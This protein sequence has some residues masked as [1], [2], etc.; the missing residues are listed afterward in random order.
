MKNSH[1]FMILHLL[2]K[3]GPAIKIHYCYISYKSTSVRHLSGEKIK[4]SLN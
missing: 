1:N 2:P 4:S 3:S